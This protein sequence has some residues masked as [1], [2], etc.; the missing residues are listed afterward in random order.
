MRSVGLPVCS[1]LSSCLQDLVEFL[2]HHGCVDLCAFGEHLGLFLDQ[3]NAT[4]HLL[5]AS[6]IAFSA[7]LLALFA[8]L[9]G[10]LL[11]FGPPLPILLSALAQQLVTVLG[12]EKKVP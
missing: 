7:L 10:T 11:L 2:H 8:F 4:P 6:I 5:P 3:W 1:F 12:P 9:I